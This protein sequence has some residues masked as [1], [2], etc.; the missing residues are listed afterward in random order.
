MGQFAMAIVMVPFLVALLY[1]S[2]ARTRRSP[3]FAC[4][5]ISI[6]FSWAATAVVMYISVGTLMHM[7]PSA[8]LMNTV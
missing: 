7:L 8:S 1:F 3:M 4:I 2:N 5:I 6:L